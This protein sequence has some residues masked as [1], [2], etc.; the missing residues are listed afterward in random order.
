[1]QKLPLPIT[2]DED[3][4]DVVDRSLRAAVEPL[5]T[6]VRKHTDVKHK[7]AGTWQDA[8][9]K[10]LFKWKL[11]TIE[12]RD[13]RDHDRD[14]HILIK[15]VLTTW[16]NGDAWPGLRDAGI[17]KEHIELV[18][19]LRNGHAHNRY[20]S[21]V[22]P[23]EP[24]DVS[25]GLGALRAVMD[26][27]GD[28]AA[29]QYVQ[30][31]Y[32]VA[33]RRAKRV[34]KRKQWKGLRGDEPS[35]TPHTVG[36]HWTEPDPQTR[37]PAAWWLIHLDPSDQIKSAPVPQSTTDVR[38]YL[39]KFVEND[40]PVLLGCA[41]CFSVPHWLGEYR[42]S[43]NNDQLPECVWAV[44][45]EA[46]SGAANAKDL[47]RSI[48]EALGLGDGPFWQGDT[49]VPDPNEAAGRMSFRRTEKYVQRATEAKPSSVF[50]VGGDASVG[51]LAL[52]GMPML[53]WLRS[54]GFKIWPFDPHGKRTVVEIFPRS[55]WSATQ[56]D[57]AVPSL[58]GDR[59]RFLDGHPYGDGGETRETL[60]RER[61]AFDALMTAWALRNYGGNISRSVRGS[62][63]KSAVEGEIWLPTPNGA[64]PAA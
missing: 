60:L 58:P 2:G 24:G 25:R 39:A 40:Q 64:R 9:G 55:L 17:S 23:F 29:A 5:R 22:E 19:K 7:Y 47:V 13:I 59:T 27:I 54:I 6:Y 51:G 43:Q 31:A 34:T 45:E 16:D 12:S 63:D 53:R 44:V 48:N 11:G 28:K 10:A 61:R 36:L 15:W 14:P 33:D 26:A 52:W 46:A 8:V 18:F 49:N 42:A 35:D 21:S 4:P 37:K 32:E 57:S 50:R 56:F 3:L 41:F 1:M 20:V 62:K 38:D 30:S